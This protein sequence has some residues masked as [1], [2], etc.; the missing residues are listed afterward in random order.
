MDQTYEYITSRTCTWPDGGITDTLV[1]ERHA[2]TFDPPSGEAAV[3]VVVVVEGT[4]HSTHEVPWRDPCAPV[5]DTHTRQHIH[6]LTHLYA[7]PSL[8][9]QET[10]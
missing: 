9:Q 8:M 6:A 2:L 7:P 4:Q 10:R 3:A 5:L 1:E